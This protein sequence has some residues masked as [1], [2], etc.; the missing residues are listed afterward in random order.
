MR[1]VIFGLALLST[2]SVW[3]FSVNPAH[4][5]SMTY[6]QC[7]ADPTV[8]F[9]AGWYQQKHPSTSINQILGILCKE[10]K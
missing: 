1:K 6:S 10:A 3:A 2:S 5:K 7:K 8:R 9:V 4:I